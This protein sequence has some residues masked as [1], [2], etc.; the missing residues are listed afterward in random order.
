MEDKQRKY[1]GI[2]RSDTVNTL[3]TFPKIT[4]TYKE[5]YDNRSRI[6]NSIVLLHNYYIKRLAYDKT[7]L[8]EFERDFSVYEKPLLALLHSSFLYSG[9]VYDF[10]YRVTR[11]TNAKILPFRKSNK[12][13]FP[14][15]DEAT[16]YLIQYD[17]E[18]NGVG[19]YSPNQVLVS[20]Q[21]YLPDL[22]RSASFMFSYQ[23]IVTSDI[24]TEVIAQGG[25]LKLPD[26]IEDKY[27]QYDTSIV[28]IDFLELLSDLAE[29]SLDPNFFEEENYPIL[30]EIARVYYYNKVKRFVVSDKDINSKDP[31]APKTLSELLYLQ[32][33]ISKN[34]QSDKYTDIKGTQF[35]TKL[36][37]KK[38]RPK[39][40]DEMME[41]SAFLGFDSFLTVEYDEDINKENIKQAEYEFQIMKKLGLLPKTN[42]LSK[43]PYTFRVRKL[44]REKATGMYIPSCH[45]LLID[46]TFS[47]I[48][49]YGHLI[50]FSLTETEIS[51]YSDK[52]EFANIRQGYSK[53]LLEEYKRLSDDLYKNYSN[54]NHKKLIYLESQ[55][56]YFQEFTEIYARAYEHYMTARGI[57]STLLGT[58]EQ[59]LSPKW[60]KSGIGRVAYDAFNDP[61][62]SKL[63]LDYFDNH[64]AV[65]TITQELV[66]QFNTMAEIVDIDEK[67]IEKSTVRSIQID[68]FKLLTEEEFTQ[69]DKKTRQTINSY[70]K[71]EIESVLL[72][73]DEAFDALSDTSDFLNTNGIYISNNHFSIKPVINK[74]KKLL[75]LL[76]IFYTDG[77]LGQMPLSKLVQ[78]SYSY[79]HK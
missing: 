18:H 62:L 12:D 27:H 70:T 72:D 9:K 49:E 2:K 76:N 24:Q 38:N 32:L 14:E 22:Y 60:N 33:L 51:R 52:P 73:L 78:K 69:L 15:R 43:H 29:T 79:L 39:I 10:C 25:T 16:Y 64:P 56:G 68:N 30:K 34:R 74:D 11:I 36:V 41:N 75:G 47:F 65:P 37:T 50:D 48:H 54:D 66:S 23:S 28:S 63:V 53:Y 13:N 59:N 5:L 17:F 7:K 1:D 71:Q 26:T 19:S 46:K 8:I 44:G 42:T 6:H 35:A 61:K 55:L 57:K 40:V 45:M 3:P 21:N 67:F 20:P 4:K 77:V 31:N 58:I